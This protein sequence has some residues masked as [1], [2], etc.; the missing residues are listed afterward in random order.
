M[1]EDIKA[2]WVKALRSGEY[3]QGTGRLRSVDDEFCC[4]GV[5]CDVVKKDERSPF[6]KAWH[7]FK[8]LSAWIFGKPEDRTAGSNAFLPTAV[9]EWV[10]LE[11]GHTQVLMRMNDFERRSFD[12]IADWIEV[13]C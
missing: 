13:A 5:L 1:N 2:A 6:H 7:W 4:L 3:R 12:E 8:G 10:G 9:H 11:A